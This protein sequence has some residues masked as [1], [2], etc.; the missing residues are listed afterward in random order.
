MPPSAAGRRPR[1]RGSEGRQHPAV[2]ASELVVGAAGS[3]HG[4]SSEF[5]SRATRKP[6]CGERRPGALRLRAAQRRFRHVG[7]AYEPPRRSPRERRAR[8]LP[9]VTGVVWIGRVDAAHP[10]P[11]VAGHVL[12]TVRARSPGVAADRRRSAVLRPGTE[13]RVVGSGRRLV[14][15]PGKDPAVDPARRLLPLGLGRQ[16]RPRPATEG[17]RVVPVDVGDGM[18]LE[19]VGDGSARA[20]AAEPGC[21]VARTNAPYCAFVTAVAE[22]DTAPTTTSC[23]GLSSGAV[24]PPA[25]GWVVPEHH[26][27]MRA[28]RRGRRR[29]AGRRPRLP[30]A[31]SRRSGR[32]RRAAGRAGRSTGSR[33]HR[34]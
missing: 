8:I 13:R 6:M 19:R 29:A 34:G 30:R 16:A 18:P 7:L 10:F 20:S 4:A 11:D 9:P 1:H 2:G 5:P 32:P 25:G 17:G 15:A 31:E 27:A 3:G 26:L 23:R 12:E 24:G 21:P 28:R 33:L 14:G 22:S